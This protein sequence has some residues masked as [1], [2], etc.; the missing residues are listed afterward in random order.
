MKQGCFWGSIAVSDL[1]HTDAQAM[2]RAATPKPP[3]ATVVPMSP[4]E[5]A[6]FERTVPKQ[7]HNYANVFSEAAATSLPPH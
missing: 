6:E 5:H 4:E 2:L 1:L 3:P 7:Y